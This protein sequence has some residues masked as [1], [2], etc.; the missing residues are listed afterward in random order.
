MNLLLISKFLLIFFFRKVSF[1]FI[2]IFTSHGPL[3]N[4]FIRDGCR[5]DRDV[6]TLV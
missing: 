4:M 3:L 2:M 6:V 5:W 1:E